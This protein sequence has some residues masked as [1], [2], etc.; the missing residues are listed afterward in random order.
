MAL[1]LALTPFYTRVQWNTLHWPT[2]TTALKNLPL[3]AVTRAWALFNSISWTKYARIR[4]VIILAYVFAGVKHLGELCLSLLGTFQASFT[5][6]P[7][8][9]FRTSKVKALLIYLAV[10]SIES[11]AS[12]RREALMELLWPGLPLKSAQDNLRQTLYQLR[13]A[14]SKGSAGDGEEPLQLI[15][16]SRLAIGLNPAYPVELDVVA[17]S[18]HLKEGRL[19]AAA[20]LYRGDFLADFYLADSSEFEQWAMSWRSALRRQALEA[21]DSLTITCLE[22]GRFELAQTYAGQ[23]LAIDDLRERA[24]RQLMTALARSGQRSAALAQYEICRQRLAEEL[25]VEPS[26]ETGALL[27]QIEADAI[28]AP[29]GVRMPSVEPPKPPDQEEVEAA[30]LFVG[31]E[32]ELGT[33]AA[34]LESA[35]DGR[36]QVRFVIGGAGRG[37]TALVTN[38]A[39]LAQEADPDLL[40]ISGYCYGPAGF[41]DLYHPFRQALAQL[42]GDVTGRIGGTLVNREQARRLWA[43]MPLTVPALV[44]EA[45]DLVET[46]VPGSGLRHRAATFA[47]PETGWFQA[48]SERLEQPSQDGL[49]QE[50]LFGQVTAL[51]KHVAGQ[52]PLLFLL[53]DL[54]WADAASAALLFHLSLALGESRI[55]LLGTYRPEEIALDRGQ[56]RH[57][58]ANIAGELKRQHGDI[59]IDL[60][61]AA[62]AEGR[63]FIDAY[64]DSEP[65]WLDEGFR[66]AFFDHT[67]GHALF[68]VELLRAMQERSD[69]VRDESG[70]WQTAGTIDWDTL[71]VRVE[72]V[73]EQRFGRLDAGL[74]AVLTTASV[75]GETF[76]AGVIA[77]VQGLKEQEVVQR[78][79]QEL[80]RQHRLVAAE[81]LA[82]AGDQR[83]ARYRFRHQLF[84][85]YLYQGLDEVERAYQH[86]A[87]GRAL[88]GLYGDEARQAAA[89]LAWHFDRAGL[90]EKALPYLLQAGDE[91][92][93]L[94]AAGEATRHYERA[95]AILKEQGEYKRA[96]RVLMK[97]GLAYHSA[98]DYDRSRR[99]FEESFTL[100][101]RAGDRLLN[102]PLPKPPHALRVSNKEP[103]TVDVTKTGFAASA[104]MQHQLFSGL[105]RLTPE[106]DVVPDV[107]MNWEISAGG[108]GYLFYLRQDVYWSDGVPV[109]AGDFVYS[110]RRSLNPST[111]YDYAANLYDIKGATAYHQG[112]SEWLGVQALDER[113]LWVEVERPTS[114]F[115]QLLAQ[116]QAMPLPR[117]A[118]ETYGEAWTETDHIVSNGPFLLESWDKGRSMVLRRYQAYHGH[119]Q[120]NVER[121]ELR[122]FTDPENLLDLFEND[123]LDELNIME[124]GLLAHAH[125]MRALRWHAD[126]YLNYAGFGTQYIRF[127]VSR[128][129]F[130][131]SRVR[132]AFVLATDRQRLVQARETGKAFPVTGGFVPSDLPGHVPD[133]ALT[134]N[135]E[136][137]RRLLDEAG[138][139][140]GRGLPPLTALLLPWHLGQIPELMF[141]PWKSELGVTISWE[142]LEPVDIPERIWR[143]KPHL[144][145][146]GWLADYPDPDNFLR[147]GIGN[148]CNW[149]HEVY[150]SLVEQ[151]RHLMD[152]SE[153]LS[154]YRQAEEILVEEAPILPLYYARRHLL[155]K[156]WIRNYKPQ[157]LY[158]CYWKDVIIEP[159]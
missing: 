60:S 5:D 152:Q 127:D 137:A 113:T 107:A 84:Q 8:P 72:G 87:V 55:L 46:F 80:E 1:Y 27:R 130:D 56:E 118:V 32:R 104:M 111:G 129:P 22:G 82:W 150:N 24:T 64:L 140:G 41:G 30:P 156:P 35:R 109:T 2:A 99:A 61:E 102:K 51:L 143:E 52:R 18:R 25:G 65:N 50:R 34:T 21:L 136:R 131:D 103:V 14:V 70:H 124:T 139:P 86:E 117:H 77:Q 81:G 147:T 138:Y 36:G 3:P 158:N 71:P 10:E 116:T 37:K 108:R 142:R 121:V 120:G 153:R 76:T 12:F 83:L 28:R 100:R 78:L 29:S 125:Y 94:Y 15:T 110:W 23:Q 13:K 66:A 128:S 58:L 155:V 145:F 57:P 144:F 53:E 45:P 91:A 54:H 48:L 106:L 154:L 11:T 141:K 17:F 73:V 9:P 44:T 122:F 134:Y 16:S 133:I 90:G 101:Q 62:E 42:S 43:A 114:Y 79:S 159:H 26:Q 132:R 115:L 85:Q 123:T 47:G 59:W 75:E 105:V 146:W 97:L 88:E 20:G 92:R 39:R 6:R 69:L 148:I 98:F 38:F 93:N 96:A 89:Q 49:Q 74:Q 151:A 7:L 67:G 68:T 112:E 135:P 31:R 149:Q 4:R 157:A 119:S 19:E 95:L 40:I 126:N 33:L 63:A